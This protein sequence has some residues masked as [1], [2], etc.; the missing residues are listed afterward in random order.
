MDQKERIL[1]DVSL[2][3]PAPD[4]ESEAAR[5]WRA[6][7]EQQVEANQEAGLEN[8]IPFNG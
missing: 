4:N 7:M 2:G 6:L 3:K 5:H 8:M 1:R